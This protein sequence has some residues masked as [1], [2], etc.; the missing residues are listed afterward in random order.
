MEENEREFSLEETFNTFA[1]R[2]VKD[3]PELEGKFAIYDAP[4]DTLY[5]MPDDNKKDD[6]LRIGRKY[7]LITR[8]TGWAAYTHDP[9][10]EGEGY[11]L[12]T[13]LASPYFES[14][15]AAL[16][17]LKHELGHLVAPG[18]LHARRNITFR[19]CVADI[20]SILYRNESNTDLQEQILDRKG[21]GAVGIV[22]GG[23]MQHF[24]LLTTLELENL[25]KGYD[26]RNVASSPLQAANLAYRLSLRYTLPPK[27]MAEIAKFFEPVQQAAN[28]PER[29]LIAAIEKCAEIV[30]D[31]HSQISRTAYLSAR[32][33]LM[34]FLANDER[35]IEWRK[36]WLTPD[37]WT[38]LQ[39]KIDETDAVLL[40][41]DESPKPRLIRET[42]DMMVLGCFDK[43]PNSKIDP[44]QYE[45]KENVDYL[46]RASLAYA[47][48]RLQ[49]PSLS[50]KETI[51]LARQMA[52]TP[53]ATKQT[54]PAPRAKGM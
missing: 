15:S 41:E 39:R 30:F 6:L 3:F 47:N 25:S 28:D 29:G 52:K 22:L 11:Y 46:N 48:L 50:Q 19:E 10:A 18:G 33:W 7:A 43:D 45:S 16:S 4:T 51:A 37:F 8:D 32:T 36:K 49:Q 31:E 26:L 14:S 40:K 9:A 5:G 12:M 1:A 44:V 23:E 2:A 20:F 17:T 38:E 13:I 24:T 21:T 34:N 54:P 42:K 53:P 35:H 27:E